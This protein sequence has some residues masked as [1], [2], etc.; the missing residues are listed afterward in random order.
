MM[1]WSLG[2]ATGQFVS[3]LISEKKTDLDI[4]YFNPDRS[5]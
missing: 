2:P 4:Q 3:D 1:G 5:F